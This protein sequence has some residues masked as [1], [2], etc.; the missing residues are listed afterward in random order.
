MYRGNRVI[1]ESLH[2][3]VILI[4]DNKIIFIS[5]KLRNTYVIHLN[6]NNYNVKCF[7]VL[8]DSPYIWH[9]RLAPAKIELIQ[10]PSKKKLVRGLPQFE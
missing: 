6:D 8:V 4:I 9:R 1:F 7:S 10:K 2:C 5:E 3:V